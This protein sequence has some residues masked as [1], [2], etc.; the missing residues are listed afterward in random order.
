[1]QR[2]FDLALAPLVLDTL[3]LVVVVLMASRA[4]TGMMVPG[5]HFSSAFRVTNST[6][7][8]SFMG[9]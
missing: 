8:F 1:M 5:F 9:N 7:L 2:D 3:L 4:A 6:W